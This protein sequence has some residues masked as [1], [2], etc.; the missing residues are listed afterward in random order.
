MADFSLHLQ[1]KDLQTLSDCAAQYTSQPLKPFRGA[2]ACYLDEADRGYFLV[3][4]NWV[5]AMVTLVKR[6]NLLQKGLNKWRQITK[7]NKLEIQQL[8]R[9]LPFMI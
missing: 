4:D 3:N 7:R 2:L 5:D 8:K 1:P 9:K 6:K